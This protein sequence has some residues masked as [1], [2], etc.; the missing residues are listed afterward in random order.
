MNSGYF[1]KLLSLIGKEVSGVI[2]RPYH[3]F[4]PE[5]SNI[6]YEVNYGYIED[7]Y[8]PDGE[9]QDIYYLGVKEPLEK[10]CGIVIAIIHRE[11]DSEDKL[12]VAPRGINFSNEEIEKMVH[13]QEQYFKYQIIR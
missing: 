11:D 6:F 13:F 4:H 5:H 12:V 7:L 9:E 8:A 2:D 10:F 3:S 1:E